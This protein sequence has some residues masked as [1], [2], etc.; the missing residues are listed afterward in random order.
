MPSIIK[1]RDGWRALVYVRGQRESKVF[2]RKADAQLWADRR[3]MEL[4][5][6]AEGRASEFRTLREALERYAREVS[7]EHKGARWEQVRIAA[8][9]RTHELPLAL[10]LGRLDSRILSDWQARRRTQV[11]DGTVLRELSLLSSLF[12][13]CRDWGWL[14]HNPLENL[15][16]PAQPKHRTRVF[17]WREIRAIL[18][19]LG[20][21]PGQPP[22]SMQQVVAYAFLLSLHTGMRA[23]EL[24]GL[25]WP[26]VQGA[27][28]TLPE[29]KNGTARDVPLSRRARR[30]IERL[31]GL[32]K[33]LPVSAQ[34]RD[35]LFRKARLRAGLLDCTFHDARHTAAT[36][37]GRS[38]GQ[39]GKLSFPEFCSVFGWRDPKFALVYVNPTAAQL[40]ERL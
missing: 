2:A 21:R 31:R 19:Q 38:V 35:A 30:L 40:A 25:T 11:T 3:R 26:A 4:L 12:R 29:T 33:P 22:L 9:L 27:W 32:D 14:T 18:R 28:V 8:F 34:T 1:H 20:Y 39:P 17:T 36:R 10:P 7:P 15:R 5:Q 13:H 6:E 23:G 37:I 24:L 16:R